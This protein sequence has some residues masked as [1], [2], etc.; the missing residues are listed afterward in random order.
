[1]KL[2]ATT[3]TT[4]QKITARF[5]GTTGLKG[6]KTKNDLWRAIQARYNGWRGA[7]GIYYKWGESALHFG[8]AHDQTVSNVET[9]WNQTHG[10]HWD[11]DNVNAHAESLVSSQNLLDGMV[12]E[13]TEGPLT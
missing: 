12:V 6:Q 3:H 2:F 9:S 8:L 10:L 13:K 1:M 7:Q 11:T 5:N 4:V